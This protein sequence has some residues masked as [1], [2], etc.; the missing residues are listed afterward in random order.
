M[1]HV[2]EYFVGC[3]LGAVHLVRSVK[4][5]HWTCCNKDAVALVLHV[6]VESITRLALPHVRVINQVL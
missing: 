1:S 2:R 3:M 5:S 6:V 4:Y